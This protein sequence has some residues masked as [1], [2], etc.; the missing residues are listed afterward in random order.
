MQLTNKQKLYLK[1][2]AHSLKPVVLLG[3]QGCTDGVFAEIERAL[4]AHEL[5]KVRIPT[6]DRSLKHQVIAQIIKGTKAT[7]VNTIGHILT[8]YRP[9]QAQKITLPQQ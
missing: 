5:I 1:S 9:A 4:E 3:Q 6:S 8:L 7:Q 2:Q